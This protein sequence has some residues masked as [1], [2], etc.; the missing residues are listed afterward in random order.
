MEIKCSDIFLSGDLPWRIVLLRLFVSCNK[1]ETK[2]IILK[3]NNHKTIIIIILERNSVALLISVVKSPFS[4][5]LDTS[6]SGQPSR[7][8]SLA[9]S[10]LVLHMRSSPRHA[11][12]CNC[13]MDCV[14]SVIHGRAW[15]GEPLHCR[16]D[17]PL[18]RMRGKGR[19]L[20]GAPTSSTL[21]TT[22]CKAWRKA[23]KPIFQ[24]CFLPSVNVANARRGLF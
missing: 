24:T 12:H 21:G 7:S 23:R 4:S 2:L 16:G 17:C 5:C 15:Q 9:V 6:S 22:W 19:L 11:W 10:P 1:T 3:Q 8:C 18:F 14:I 20:P 13:L